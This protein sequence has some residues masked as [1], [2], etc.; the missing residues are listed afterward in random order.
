MGYAEALEGAL[1]SIVKNPNVKPLPQRG[2]SLIDSV[3]N[4]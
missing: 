2:K 4:R 3:A 1:K